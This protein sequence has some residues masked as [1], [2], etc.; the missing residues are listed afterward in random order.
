MTSPPDQIPHHADL[1]AGATAGEQTD[2]QIVIV[3]AGPAGLSAAF[4]L[5]KAGVSSTVLEAGDQ[6]G[7]LGSELACLCGCYPP[8]PALLVTCFRPGDH[9]PTH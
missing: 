3:G 5:Q 2:H 9:E 6:V 7:G 1:L 4:E 8:D